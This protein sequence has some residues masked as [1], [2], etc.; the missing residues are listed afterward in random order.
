[1]PFNMI[2][3]TKIRQK[4][5]CINFVE[6]RCFWSLIDSPTNVDQKSTDGTRKYGISTSGSRYLLIYK[7]TSVTEK[8]RRVYLSGDK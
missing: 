8:L 2:Y 7:V 6:V 3:S 5:F 4:T 1:M